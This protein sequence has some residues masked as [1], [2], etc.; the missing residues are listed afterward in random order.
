MTLLDTRSRAPGVD[1]AAR[2]A[3]SKAAQKAMDRRARRTGHSADEQQSWAR[4]RTADQD[5]PAP[6]PSAPRPPLRDRIANV[7]FVV[8]VVVLIIAGMALTLWLSTKSAQDSYDLSIARAEN[9]S[10]TDQRDALKRTFESADAAPDLSDSAARLGMVPVRNPARMVVGPDG[11]PR[12]FGTPEAATGRAPRSI[13]PAKTDDP[14]AKID[15]SKVDDSEG[16]PGSGGTAAGG[17]ATPSTSPSTP[18]PSATSPAPT[19]AP[20]PNGSA[21][22]PNVLPGG[23]PGPANSGRGR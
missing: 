12:V 22:T 2:P 10:L 20:T 14:T 6:A 9:Q 13:N 19:S 5:R 4:R 7:P 15:V 3:R 1:D 23:A 11:K 21:P 16:L 8:P 17:S 18:A